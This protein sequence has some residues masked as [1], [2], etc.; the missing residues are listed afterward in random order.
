MWW[1]GG[2]T[3]A[4]LPQNFSR[5]AEFLLREHGERQSALRKCG[6]FL[7]TKETKGTKGIKA[8]VSE[9]QSL[10][11]PPTTLVFFSLLS[12]V[13]WFTHWHFFLGVLGGCISD[14]AVLLSVGSVADAEA[15]WPRKE[16]T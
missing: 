4:A 14:V 8:E 12:S 9:E 6:E 7:T 5:E 15:T 1:R 3:A 2:V 13:S 11:N 10:A 16:A